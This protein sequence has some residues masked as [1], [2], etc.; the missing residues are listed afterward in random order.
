[1]NKKQMIV[2]LAM[3]VSTLGE[4]TE[5]G[6]SIPQ[7]TIYL[8]L[9]TNYHEWAVITGA[10]EQIGWLKT[11]AERVQ[12]TPKGREKAAEFAALGI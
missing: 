10:G 1:M 8:A 9:G 11:T 7:S 2:K 5:P 4:T 6:Q 12:L 3:I